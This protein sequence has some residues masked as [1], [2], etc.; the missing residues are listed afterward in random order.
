M[1]RSERWLEGTLIGPP[2][3]SW[4]LVN[5]ASMEP[6]LVAGDLVLVVPLGDEKPAPG[7]VVLARSPS[8]SLIVH[9]FVGVNDGMAVTMGDARAIPDPAIPVSDLI[10]R[11]EAV[12]P[13]RW[14]RA[15]VRVRRAL[16][17]IS[18]IGGQR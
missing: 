17:R 9:R 10:G 16:G 11:I 15:R 14:R 18:R 7:D 1:S 12:R 5:G 4:V 8:S 2:G 13:A 6:S 3:G